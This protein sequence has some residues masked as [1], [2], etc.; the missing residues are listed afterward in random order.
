MQ[1][2]IQHVEEV[3]ERLSGAYKKA[4][5]LMQEKV[6]RASLFLQSKIVQGLAAGTYG[7]KSRRGSAGLAGSVRVTPSEIQG[8]LVEGFVTG[9]GGTSWY[10]KVHE[11]GGTRSY[12]IEPTSAKALAWK[13][14]GSSGSVGKQSAFAFTRDVIFARKVIHP[15]LPQRRWMGEPVSEGKADVVKIINEIKSEQLF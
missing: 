15:P 9:A 2:Q 6:N 4:L 8:D 3:K 12:T 7:I 5:V 1:I 11:F 13:P 10:G 14:F